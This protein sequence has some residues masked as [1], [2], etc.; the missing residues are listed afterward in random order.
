MGTPRPRLFKQ[1]GQLA[2]STANLFAL[3]R[4][5]VRKTIPRQGWWAATFADEPNHV[6]HRAK[7][8]EVFALDVL[9]QDIRYAIQVVSLLSQSPSVHQPWLVLL[10]R[11]QR[12]VDLL[13]HFALI[14]MARMEF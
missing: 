11:P 12:T 9:M 5:E 6:G 10:L 3:R 4:R 1:A 14:G 2:Y 13:K 7:R 8:R